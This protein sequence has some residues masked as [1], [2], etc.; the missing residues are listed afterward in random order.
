MIA[1]NFSSL[2]IYRHSRSTSKK[3]IRILPPFPHSRRVS[4]GLC[5]SPCDQFSSSRKCLPKNSILP[6]GELGPT[7]GA[8]CWN[9]LGAGKAL[10]RQAN[11]VDKIGFLY[12][13]RTDFN[14]Q[15]VLSTTFRFLSL[16]EILQSST[17]TIKSVNEIVVFSHVP[18]T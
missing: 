13:C 18:L 17:F 12:A 1:T 6:E 8:R 5:F 7:K 15:C 4:L 10:V 2:R 3:I 14:M 11:P 16:D 9:L